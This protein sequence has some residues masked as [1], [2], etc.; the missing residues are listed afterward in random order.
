MWEVFARYAGGLERKKRKKR[1]RRKKLARKKKTETEI[2]PAAAG[3][4]TLKKTK[5][6]KDKKNNKTLRQRLR[7]RHFKEEIHTYSTWG[8]FFVF[9]GGKARNWER[10]VGLLGECRVSCRGVVGS[11]VACL[12]REGAS[13]H[14]CT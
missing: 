12:Q 14:S 7:M 4:S 13:H 1:K 3:R 10:E 5:N 2:E 8:F 9:L 11:A 6:S